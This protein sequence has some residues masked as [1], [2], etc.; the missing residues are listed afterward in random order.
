V[1]GS[2]KSSRLANRSTHTHRRSY[3]LLAG[4][5]TNSRI[6]F[7]GL[8][9]RRGKL[10]W[11]NSVKFFRRVSSRDFLFLIELNVVRQSQRRTIIWGNWTLLLNWLLSPSWPSRCS[12]WW[13]WWSRA[14]GW[15]S[16]SSAQCSLA[17]C[18]QA[19]H[20]SISTVLA[21]LVP[22]TP[23]LLVVLLA[24]LLDGLRLL[25]VLH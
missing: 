1:W 13:P 11:T 6:Y 9:K 18:W 23:S 14:C 5:Q 16:S 12:C 2:S 19:L 17:F 24:F 20:K 7:Q 15:L 3:N 8:N 4:G 21:E 25:L 10:E 22:L